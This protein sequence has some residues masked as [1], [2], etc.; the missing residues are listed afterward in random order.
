MDERRRN[1]RT[2]LPSNVIIKK[3]LGSENK[4]IQIELIDVSR[5]GIGFTCR[6][7]LDI[8]EVYESYL[9]IWTKEVIHSFLQIVRI[10]M[11]GQKD[12]FL[13]GA[14]FVGMPELEANRIGVYQTIHENEE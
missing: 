2:G 12:E 10:E 14:S 13:Y 4:E 9:T 5:G 1:K 6:E 11:K 3:M 7:K 8:G